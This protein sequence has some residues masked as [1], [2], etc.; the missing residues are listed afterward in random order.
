MD[1]VDALVIGSKTFETVLAFDTWPY[2]KKLVFVLSTR[3]LAPAP[4]GAVVNKC[5][6]SWG[7][8]VTP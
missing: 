5:R 6:G 8:R 2:D 4:A 7:N 3:Q 1:T